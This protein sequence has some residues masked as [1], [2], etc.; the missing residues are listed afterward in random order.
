M[1]VS[2]K[3]NYTNEHFKR[4]KIFARC[5]EVSITKAPKED[6]VQGFDVT[7]TIF[8]ELTAKNGLFSQKP[9]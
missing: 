4:M 6:P 5:D 9:M 2:S 3:G 1:Y 7:I 8:V